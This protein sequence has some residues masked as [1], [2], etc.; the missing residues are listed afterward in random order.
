MARFRR[1]GAAAGVVALLAGMTAAVV[2][3]T[4]TPAFAAPTCTYN[5]GA[6][7]PNVVPGTTAV[8]V[9]C[10]GLTPNEPL[11]LIEA[12]PL[13]GVVD[14]ASFQL[15]D[16][17]I[18]TLNTP[19]ADASGNLPPLPIP[20]PAVNTFTDG[21]ASCPPSP[22][23]INAGLV[24]CAIAVAD[25]STLALL[26]EGL[27]VYQGQGMPAAPPTLAITPSAGIA[28][29]VLHASDASAATTFWTGNA[30]TTVTGLTS[31]IGG[32]AAANTLSVS[33]ALYCQA[34]A[35]KPGCSGIAVGTVVP[36]ALSGTI[37]VPPGI[38]GG[39]RQVVVDEP[40][41]TPFPGTGPGGAVQGTTTFTQNGG[42]L[43][44]LTPAR[45]MDTR[46]NLGAHGPVAPN[47][48]VSLVVL[49]HGGV[50]ASGV[51][52]VMLNV[53]VTQPTAPG[54][55]TVFPDGVAKPLASNLNFVP[56]QTVPNSVL[57]PVGADGKVDFFNGSTG[58][59]QLIADVSAY[60]ASGSPAAGGLAPLTP[61]RLMDTRSNLGAN[62][63]V[64]A[65]GTV[66][67]AVLGHG[68]VPASGVG[69]VVL[70]VTV[71]SPAAP[72]FITVFPDGVA[73]PLASNLNFIPGQTVPNAVVAPVGANGK[74]DFF[75]GSTGTVQLIADVSGWFASGS[76]GPGGLTPLTPARLM[77]TRSNLGA[78]GPVAANG[79]VSLPVVGHGG[80]PASGVGA[81][82]LNVTVT[83]PT[84]PGF[85]TVFPDGVAKPLASNLNFIPGQTV[86]N[87]VVAPVGADG[88]V[89]FF[90]GS[91]G[92]AQLIVDVSG[93]FASS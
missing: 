39:S 22:A 41:S 37:T 61:A 70:N 82:V 46:S 16:V 25:G 45:L 15:N 78:N 49:G 23:Q 6:F 20:I 35:V 12:S 24:A 53:T 18:S 65:N 59:V 72:G 7:V 83:S 31:T 64:A 69:A 52:A 43:A 68:G 28:G 85:I 47:G 58:T 74:V 44:P 26:S 57:A 27:L 2:G 73:K 36:P 63:P 17:D 84:A 19:T 9:A 87:A 21:N 89:D 77:D 79:T 93:W 92:T 90:N 29:T 34:A 86:P 80:V 75:N 67:L 40:N 10:T 76:P 42:A 51:G 81:V 91:T 60:L 62:G 14:P 33:P 48:T 88:K 5:G 1:A 11:I 32:I 54:F 56:G 71:T 66:S 38:P 50:P 8:N 3:I 55:I 13:A 30:L 4:A